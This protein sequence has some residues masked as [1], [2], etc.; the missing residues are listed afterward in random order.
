VDD[1]DNSPD[2]RAFYTDTLD[3]MGLQY[4]VW[5]TNNSD[6]E[7]FF[8]DLGPYRAVLWFTGDEFG[9]AAGPGTA[10]ESALASWLDQGNACLLLSAMDYYYDR[11]LTPFMQDYLGV[12]DAD[13]DTSQTTVTGAGTV[14]AGLGP[15]SLSYPGSNWSDTLTPGAGAAETFSGNAGTAAVEHVTEDYLTVFMGFAFEALPTPADRQNVLQ[16]FLDHCPIDQQPVFSD[17]FESGD[18]SAWQ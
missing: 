10:G 16:T 2:V 15:Y 9:G 17:G 18:V 7:P 3:A 14:F 13:S 4:E 1:D 6:T 11:G 8:G 12:G 5:D